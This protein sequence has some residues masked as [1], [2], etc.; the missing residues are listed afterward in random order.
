MRVLV[1]DGPKAGESFTVEHG[2][3]IGTTETARIRLAGTGLLPRHLMLRQHVDGWRLYCLDPSKPV[4]VNGEPMGGPRTLTHG[5]MIQVG[6]VQLLVSEERAAVTEK[7]HVDDRKTTTI[8]ARQSLLN[9]PDDVLKTFE[10]LKNPTEKLGALLRFSNEIHSVADPDA[11]PGKI[12]DVVFDILPADRGAVL[13]KRDGQEE[14]ETVATKRR[15]PDSL[16]QPIR[17]SRAM[18]ETVMRSKEAILARDAQHDSRFAATKTIMEQNISSA[19]CLPLVG[20][21]G[22]VFGVIHIDSEGRSNAFRTED[23]Q[24]MSAIVSQ[25]SLALENMRLVRRLATKQLQDQELKIASRLQMGLL[26]KKPPT[27]DGIEVSGMMV[28][29]RIVGGDYYDFIEDHADGRAY[30]CIGDVSGKG[31]PAGLVMVMARCFLRPLLSK[32]PSTRVAVEHLNNLLHSDLP[33]GTFMTFLLMCWDREAKSFSF[34]G[35]GHER[36]LH[37]R[38][39]TRT[40]DLVWTGG[41]GLGFAPTKDGMYEE[42]TL[43]L[44]PGDAAVLF[45]DGLSEAKNAAGEMLS[46]DGLVEIV[47]RHGHLGAEAIQSAVMTD[48]Q[49]FVGNRDQFDDMTLV[50]IKRV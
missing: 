34:T 17:A 13:Y 44:A 12:L 22:E 50:V 20:R 21:E 41:V 37:Y 49:D 1:I 40:V 18:V 3:V 10:G 38:A 46:V 14:L 30:L 29:A 2:D 26:P 6:T 36:I 43:T 4:V 32:M 48:V 11:L 42:H 9:T 15:K 28:P 23:L 7:A 47:R 16:A 31:L 45:T 19:M 27:I 24:F 5:D 33:I 35:G 25:A 8:R 39:E